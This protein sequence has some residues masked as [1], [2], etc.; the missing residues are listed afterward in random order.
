MK[1]T[2]NRSRRRRVFT[3]LGVGAGVL[4]LIAGGGVFAVNKWLSAEF[5]PIQGSPN[6][7][8]WYGI[9]PDGATNASGDPY[10]GLLRLG[11]ANK[12][13]IVFM[14]G[15]VS[16]NDYTESRPSTKDGDTGF[17]SVRS[18][19][20]NLATLGIGDRQKDNTFRDWTVI[21]LP[22]STGDFHV[23]AGSNEVIGENGSR[24]TIRHNGSSN[25]DYVMRDVL[26]YVG[27][28]TELVVAGSSAGGFGA[29][30]MTGRAMSYFPNTS[31]VTT[32]VDGALLLHDWRA[33]STSIWKS[34]PAVTDTLKTNNFTLDSLVAL[35]DKHPQVK[36]LFTSSLR[37]KLLTEMQAYLDNGER[38]TTKAGGE[39]FQAHLTNMV[40]QL[41]ARIPDAVFYVYTGKVDDDTGL[42]QHTML[43]TDF[44]NELIDGATPMAW[45]SDAVGGQLENY[46]LDQLGLGEGDRH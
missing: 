46:G 29:A 42:T 12:V 37:D 5:A 44:H 7:N 23:G 24:Q 34:P 38:R 30:A 14:G 36:I 2:I 9:Y 45:I 8:E 11:S 26:P 43:F 40:E 16:V 31:N 32:V 25:F 18:G 20:D 33:V 35:K 3:W 10:H 6:I 28:P 27:D 1:R 15:G 19:F 22:Y 41:H 21:H 13:M 4:A 17:Y 39:A